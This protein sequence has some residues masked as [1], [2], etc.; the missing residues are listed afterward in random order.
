M[1]PELNLM[2]HFLGI[3]SRPQPGGQPDTEMPHPFSSRVP[4][5][6]RPASQPTVTPG[7]GG[8]VFGAPPMNTQSAAPAPVARPASGRREIF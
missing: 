3:T 1:Q 6:G 2:P 8:K 5:L 7:Y 4:K